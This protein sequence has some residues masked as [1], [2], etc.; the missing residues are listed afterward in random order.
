MLEI[1]KKISILDIKQALASG[2]IDVSDVSDLLAAYPSSKPVIDKKNTGGVSQIISYIGAGLVFLGIV[3]IAAI[4]W[5]NFDS[6]LKVGITLGAGLVLWLVSVLLLN[7]NLEKSIPK[8]AHFV[9]TSLV[10]FGIGVLTYEAFKPDPSQYGLYLGI[11]FLFAATIQ[12]I[13]LIFQ[14]HWANIL[15][16]YF[17]FL[18]SFWFIYAYL[19]TKFDVTTTTTEY[20]LFV[21]TGLILMYGSNF[22]RKSQV[23]IS[24]LFQIFGSMFVFAAA[25]GIATQYKWFYGFVMALVLI[26]G[27]TLGILKRYLITIGASIFWM[28]IYIQWLSGEYFK[29]QVGWGQSLIVI[30]VALIAVFQLLKSRPVPKLAPKS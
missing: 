21:L 15:S 26:A 14:R 23:H 4:Y 18:A 6:W 28:F 1:D 24:R 8:A 20:I 30:G 7:T 19:V 13:Q 9:S 17:Y 2:D 12:G 22:Y 10:S 25:F 27:L 5:E 11:G 3:F 16:F 29:D